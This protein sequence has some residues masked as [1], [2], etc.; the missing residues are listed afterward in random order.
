MK[1]RVSWVAAIALALG[2]PLA[3]VQAKQVVPM[4]GGV[5][6]EGY[7]FGKDLGPKGSIAYDE[8]TNEFVGSY[9]GL[10][11]P[12]GRRAI[13]AWLH[14]TVN[15]KTEYLGPVGWLKRGT[16]G[17]NKGRFRIKAPSQY[18]GGKF[19]SHEII[20]FTA[21]KTG[22]LKG[23]SVV[24]VPKEPSGSP[25]VANLKPAF[26][27]FAALPGADTELHYCGHGQDF[28]YAKAPEKQYCYD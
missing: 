12:A 27:L 18:A 28:F 13:F 2:L 25:Q 3:G 6:I 5:I 10:K 23:D 4:L 17:K 16:G 20:G 8:S 7:D 26:Y 24:E 21:E 14:D 19:G 22:L 15:Q 9:N 1:L 11:M